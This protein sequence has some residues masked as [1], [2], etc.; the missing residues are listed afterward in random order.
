MYT[1]D[2]NKMNPRTRER[3]IQMLVLLRDKGPM[4]ANQLVDLLDM[5]RGTVSNT[6]IALGKKGFI[7]GKYVQ[8]KTKNTTS[9]SYLYHYDPKAEH[10]VKELE[11]EIPVTAQ[12]IQN[13][14]HGM[15]A[16]K[17]DTK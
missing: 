11:L 14:M 13:I 3:A 1:D 12:D 7:Y 5:P 9:S 16:K 2:L 8:V 10:L 4:L 17:T 6:L 15:I